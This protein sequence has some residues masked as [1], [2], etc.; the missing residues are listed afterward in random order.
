MTKIQ[1]GD[2]VPAFKS[3]TQSGE[4]FSLDE[5]YANDVLDI[6]GDAK[7]RAAFEPSLVISSE[8]AGKQLPPR[9]M[10]DRPQLNK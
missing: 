2:L 7:T 4:E 9:Y 6:Y 1:I 10:G 8:G 3:Q 5:F